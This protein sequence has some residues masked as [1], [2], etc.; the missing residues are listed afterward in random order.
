MIKSTSPDTAERAKDLSQTIRD[1]IYSNAIIPHKYFENIFAYEVD[2]YGSSNLMDDANL[3][4]LL[5]LPYLGFVDKNDAIYLKTREFILSNWN[6]FW[7]S[8][9]KFHGIGSPHTGLGK[10]W[11]MG[12]C[13]RVS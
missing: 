13:M 12:L 3:P 6:K 7:F 4:S 1:S 2:G 5:S 9:E 10:I 8:G 11:P